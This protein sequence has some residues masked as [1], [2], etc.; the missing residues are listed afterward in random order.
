MRT[1]TQR[2]L[3]I[4]VCTGLKLVLSRGVYCRRDKSTRA[5]EMKVEEY[6]EDGSSDSDDSYARNAKRRRI[7]VTP[8]LF[9][10]P[11]PKIIAGNLSSLE[12][13]DND[14]LVYPSVSSDPMS[15][16]DMSS[17]GSPLYPSEAS[18]GS[19]DTDDNDIVDSAPST[20]A[21]SP[22]PRQYDELGLVANVLVSSCCSK[23]CLF[24]LSAHDVLA[25]RRKFWSMGKSDQRQWL[26]DRVHDYTHEEE[27]G[28]H[29][30]TYI[31]A[32]RQVCQLSWSKVYMVSQRR[33]SRILSLAKWLLSMVTKESKGQIPSQKAP[34][35]GCTDTS[36]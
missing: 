13:S 32:G 11:E 34:K 24:H 7:T 9:D 14:S 1:I 26:T 27:K 10:S 3:W 29:N 5:T 33:I 19:S 28:K 25:A 30:T 17:L 36:T 35:H 15:S 23:E 4:Q 18:R 21:S 2:V 8:P 16:S 20:R 22:T 6:I 12:P 31:I